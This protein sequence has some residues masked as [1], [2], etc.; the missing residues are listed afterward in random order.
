[1][2]FSQLIFKDYDGNQHLGILVEDTGVICC[3]C[4]GS[5]FELE[6]EDIEILKYLDDW[7][8]VTP[9]ALL[10]VLLEEN[11]ED[12]PKNKCDGCSWYWMDDEEAMFGT[13]HLPDDED[14]PF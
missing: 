3:L 1:M 10:P 11:Q 9:W 13:C 2:N 6:D 14:C 5:M 4:C 8:D 12:K 7:V